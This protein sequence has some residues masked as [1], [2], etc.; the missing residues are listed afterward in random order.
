MIRLTIFVNI[1]LYS[2]L[3]AQS[4]PVHTNLDDFFLPG[5]QPME[6]GDFTNPTG[7]SCHDFDN[8]DGPFFDRWKGS[9][10]A[11]ALEDPLY[12]ATVSVARQDADSSADLC[13]RCH[14]PTGWI[15]GRSTPTDGSNLTA[16]DETSVNC[17]FCHRLIKPTPIGINPYSTDATYTSDTYPIDQ[18]YLT[19]INDHIPDSS[20]NGMF[21]LDSDDRNR[22]GPFTGLASGGQHD[23][24]YSPFHE[25]G[26]LCGTCHDVSNPVYTNNGDNT[27]YLNAAQDTAPSFNPYDMFPVERTYSEWLNSDYNT[28]GGISGTVFGGTKTSVS[29]CQDCH[30]PQTSSTLRG[31]GTVRDVG[32]HEM[33]GGNTFIPLLLTYSNAA[34]R[35]SSI[36]RATRMLQSAATMDVTAYGTS[37]TVRV[38]NET[39]HKLP[40][41]YPEGRRIWLNVEAYDGLGGLI[42]ESGAYDISTGILTQ[43]ENIKIYQ[44]KPGLSQVI[45]SAVGLEHGP[46]FHFVLNDTVFSDNRIPPRGFTNNNFTAIQSPPVNYS[47]NDGVYWDETIYT[48]PQIPDSVS[49]TL[50]YQTTS[51]EY[52][53]FLRDTNYTDTKGNEMYALWNNNGKSAPVAMVH[54]SLGADD[55]ALSV[56]LSGFK[57]AMKDGFPLLNWQ[58]HSETE[59]LGFRI[60]RKAEDE[61]LF[62]EIASFRNHPELKG[63]GSSSHGKKYYYVDNDSVLIKGRTYY[64]KIADCDYQGK[65]TNF[66]PESIIFDPSGDLP[67]KSFVLDRNYPNPFNGS[68]I[69]RF[70][71]SEKQPMHIRIYDV[72]G[73]LI[74]DYPHYLY[75]AG[76]NSVEW[77]GTNSFGIMVSSGMYFYTVATRKE[78]K[79]GKMVLIK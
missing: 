39:G 76:E 3:S 51:K 62:N 35:D 48:T 37:I 56:S 24:I 73:R 4:L 78:I 40:S 26:A 18:A 21:I 65:I 52:I 9:M 7:C 15:S 34:I 44:I 38:Y 13:L 49:V 58:T 71:I 32:R 69:I 70:Y 47:Y 6:S 14:T 16:E 77:D 12:L 72:N 25:Q 66:G 17:M 22:R 57:I 28:P 68:T 30:M 67:L 60:Y 5:S 29:T 55:I 8:A 79:L 33:V 50:Y 42:F 54:Q 53:E 75:Y 61:N 31:S 74:K 23:K 41:G 45:A 27:Y 64:Y 19:G 2:I 11:Q 36:A 59:N 1:F 20:A 10:M 43:D 46:S 63:L